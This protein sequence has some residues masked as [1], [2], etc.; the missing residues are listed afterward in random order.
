VLRVAVSLG[1]E[2]PAPGYIDRRAKTVDFGA[3]A[4]T[5]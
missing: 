4:G 2:M 1:S 3:A 5:K